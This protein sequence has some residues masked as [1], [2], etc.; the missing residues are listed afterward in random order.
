[1]AANEYDLATL[2]ASE[3][4]TWSGAAPAVADT[5]IMVKNGIP[6]LITIQEVQDA[7]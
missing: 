6:Y 7:V 2:K 1:M 4:T 3:I 5:V